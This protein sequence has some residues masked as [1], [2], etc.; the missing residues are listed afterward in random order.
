M[1][2]FDLSKLEA[3]PI[4]VEADDFTY[5]DDDFTSDLFK[6]NKELKAMLFN[7]SLSVILKPDNAKFCAARILR[8]ITG[9]EED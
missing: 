5:T 4:F 7:L 9:Y 2:D 8:E 1:T 6:E 3:T